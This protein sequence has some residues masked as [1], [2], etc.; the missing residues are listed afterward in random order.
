MVVQ[1]T[2]SD[3]A[4]DLD[5]YFDAAGIAGGGVDD[6]LHFGLRVVCRKMTVVIRNS[7]GMH[8]DAAALTTT[9]EDKLF[10]MELSYGIGCSLENS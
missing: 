10:A 6:V 1:A 7:G 2:A 9:A 4:P 8:F 5:Q 3:D